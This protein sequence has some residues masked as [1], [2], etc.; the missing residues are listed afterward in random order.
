MKMEKFREQIKYCG[1]YPAVLTTDGENYDIEFRNNYD[2]WR[3]SDTV[4]AYLDCRD[5][6]PSFSECERRRRAVKNGKYEKYL[7][8]YYEN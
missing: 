5:H 1:C 3:A 2:G 8:R 6:I 7:E 4:I